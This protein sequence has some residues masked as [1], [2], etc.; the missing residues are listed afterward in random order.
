MHGRVTM[1]DV[2]KN[3][4]VDL[5]GLAQKWPSVIVERTQVGQFSGGLL[6]PKTMRN[7]DSEGRG[8]SN[9]F[10]YEGRVAYWVE[11]VIAY[12]EERSQPV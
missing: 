6:S 8:I 3:K 11:D 7:R 12:L 9:R 2:V 10:T 5:S 1:N 4:R